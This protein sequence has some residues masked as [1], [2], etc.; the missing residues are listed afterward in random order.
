M[1]P[2]WAARRRRPP[3]TSTVHQLKSVVFRVSV[4]LP[5]GRGG[6]QRQASFGFDFVIHCGEKPGS[7]AHNAIAN[8]SVTHVLTWH[9]LARRERDVS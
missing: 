3:P 4:P 8:R 2:A 7:N 9:V 1:A 5:Q 6:V